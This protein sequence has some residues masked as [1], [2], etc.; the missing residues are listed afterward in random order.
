MDPPAPTSAVSD[1]G[2][3]VPP[4][5]STFK[6][7]VMIL[8]AG[9]SLCALLVALA[10]LGLLNKPWT[11][12]WTGS[13]YGEMFEIAETKTDRYRKTEEKKLAI[14]F[15]YCHMAVG[16]PA[17]ATWL[18]QM[19]VNTNEERALSKEMREWRQRRCIPRFENASGATYHF[20]RTFRAY[21]GK[22]AQQARLY[23]P[24][25]RRLTPPQG[26]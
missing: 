17:A 7:S 19:K 5:P 8:V 9:S 3:L 18:E 2:Q 26:P 24:H 25:C 15:P 23:F 21:S 4:A 22:Y 12:T 13:E 20:D 1:N 6:F 10:M 16:S 14:Y 11:W